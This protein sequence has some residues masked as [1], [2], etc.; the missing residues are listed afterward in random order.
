MDKQ[1]LSQTLQQLHT[2]LEHTQSVDD[3][4]RESLRHLMSDIRGVLDD[5]GQPSAPR[6]QSLN[7]RLNEALLELEVS[8][9]HLS[10]LIERIVDGLNEVGI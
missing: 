2:E 4:T 5:S 8:H 1:R 9:P 3:E 10:L 6:A 7:E